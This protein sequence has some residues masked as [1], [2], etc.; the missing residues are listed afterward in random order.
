MMKSQYVLTKEKKK[1]T[2]QNSREIYIQ[3]NTEELKR[4]FQFNI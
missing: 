2:E 1:N 4:K 3:Q